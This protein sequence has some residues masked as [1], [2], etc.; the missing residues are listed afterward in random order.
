MAL[1]E[2]VLDM[3]GQVGEL[4]VCKR[5]KTSYVRRNVEKIK[6]PASRMQE[7]MR[8]RWKVAIRFYQQLPE[9]VR[10]VLNGAARDC[11]EWS[12]Y[13]FF[14][15]ENLKVLTED[16]EITDLG[17]LQFSAGTRARV[18]SLEGRRTEEGRVE[19]WWDNS[20]MTDEEEGEDRLVVVA[21][22]ENRMFSP[23]EVK[24]V[25]AAREDGFARF[26]L[27][28]MEGRKEHLYC[29]FV[30]PDG[31]GYSRTQHVAV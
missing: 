21:V 9:G 12:G 26:S 15:K 23:E 29:C 4:V 20:P 13:N 22:A 8:R 16:G 5:G 10:R 14:L 7:S 3:R 6:S 18:G 1:I 28:N 25:D 2:N 30:S 24:G 31:R 27:D 11:G 17:L 19:L